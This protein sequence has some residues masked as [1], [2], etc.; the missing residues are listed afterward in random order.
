MYL[1]YDEYTDMG[2]DEINETTFSELEFEAETIINYYTFQ[3]LVNEETLPEVVKRCMFSLIKQ[4]SMKQTAEQLPTLSTNN[5]INN[6]SVASQSNDGVSISFNTVSAK[7]LLDSFDK[8]TKGIVD[9]YLQGVTDSLGRKVLYKG[10]Y[11]N[12]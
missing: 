7:E 9:K 6:T 5:A 11:P 4:I 1:T 3:R 8:T 2:G 12:E 10:L